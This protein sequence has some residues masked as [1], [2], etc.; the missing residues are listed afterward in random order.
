MIN[1]GVT[2][3]V[4]LRRHYFLGQRHADT[5]ANTLAERTG[6]GLNTGGIAIFG[7]PRGA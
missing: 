4:E 3:T 2:L 6:G 5:I 1:Y 7:V